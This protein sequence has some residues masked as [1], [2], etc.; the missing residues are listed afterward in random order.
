MD[1][2][3]LKAQKTIKVFPRRQT[4]TFNDVQNEI[5]NATLVS[6]FTRPQVV[7]YIPTVGAIKRLSKMGLLCRNQFD[8]KRA[9]TFPFTPVR[10]T[11]G[12]MQGS[13]FKSFFSFSYQEEFSADAYN[14]A[15]A[16]SG[17]KT[18]E[19]AKGLME[20]EHDFGEQVNGKNRLNIRQMLKNCK[21]N[22]HALMRLRQKEWMFFVPL[23]FDTMDLLGVDVWFAS[24]E[25]VGD[26]IDSDKQIDR[27]KC[28][29]D[30]SL[31]LSQLDY[32]IEHKVPLLELSKDDLVTAIVK[33]EVN[34]TITNELVK[35]L[36]DLKE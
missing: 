27:R 8:D 14:L 36:T 23:G 4:I 10:V 13:S 12:D 2:V 32:L 30:A 29:I 21:S 31:A 22:L 28:D 24:F 34:Q 25:S 5:E 17:A 6:D 35:S 3:L 20:D 9:T 18:E 33:T 11:N 19:E 15:P 7:L 16:I 1:S 26:T